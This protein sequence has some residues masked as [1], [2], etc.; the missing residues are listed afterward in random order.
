MKVEFLTFSLED[1]I[2]VGD[3]LKKR[4][5][6]KFFNRETAAA[7]VCL[8][9]LLGGASLPTETPFY[10]AKGLVEYE[11]FGL[12]T[13]VAASRGAS[14]SFSQEAFATRGMSSISPLTQFKVLYNMPLS[15]ISIE[16]QLTGDN[17]V[18]YSS[19]QGLLVQARYAVSELPLLLG[20]GRVYGDGGVA[21]GFALA[22][23]EEFAKAPL[24][25]DTGDEA[26]QLF[27]SWRE[28]LGE[29]GK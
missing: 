6:V 16:H 20:A 1:E 23:K 28:T 10:Y 22:S 11:D 21:A 13:I 15:F 24:P 25:P 26:V 9:R 8:G 29:A 17:S 14:G 12:D 4:K 19:A 3:Y 2:P 18:I 7:V 27:R 5:L